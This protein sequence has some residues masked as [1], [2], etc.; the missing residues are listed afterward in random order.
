[1]AAMSEEE[2]I[3]AAIAAS[4][5]D[6]TELTT[7]EQL[8]TAFEER[9]HKGGGMIHQVNL[10][11]Q[12]SDA[13]KMLI[14]VHHAP[15]SICGYMSL[16]Y[17]VIL[18]RAFAQ[19][20]GGGGSSGD[21]H[22]PASR[23]EL[24]ELEPELRNVDGVRVEV[25]RAMS[26]VEESRRRYIEAHRD[27]FPE[28]ARK[29]YMRAWVANYE[30]SDYLR[31]EPEEVRREVCFLRFNQY[32]EY[33]SARHEER[34]RMVEEARFGGSKAGD[35]SDVAC[36]NEGDSMF[37]VESFGPTERT[38]ETPAEFL[39][40]TADPAGIS[41][42]VGGVGK[43]AQPR[44]VVLDLNGHFS[45]SLAMPATGH[46][47]G[48]D[49]GEPTLHVLNTTNTSY[50]SGMTGS[51]AM[52]QEAHEIF[53]LGG[54]AERE[55]GTGALAAE[56]HAPAGT[57]PAVDL[58]KLSMALENCDCVYPPSAERNHDTRSPFVAEGAERNYDTPLLYLGNRRVAEDAASLRLLGCT[59]V[60]NAAPSQV[61]SVLT[62]V[63][64]GGPA[65]LHVDL[66]DRVEAV[67]ATATRAAFDEAATFI[68]AA[69]SGGAAGSVVLVH[70][71]G[72]VSRSA[73]IVLFFLIA[74]K[75]MS[76]AGAWRMVREAREVIGPNTAFF[77]VLLD[78]EME[79]TG[80]ETMQRPLNDQQ[81]CFSCLDP[82]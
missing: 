82:A 15:E 47:S 1:M 70:C 29:S 51:R 46:H 27:Q 65:Y 11:N 31:A 26:F 54:A 12:F 32:P 24:A 35:K 38:L 21:G 39:T 36:Y 4:I 52:C 62:A 60:V 68:D 48:G 79:L 57:V 75:G 42:G 16:A 9:A 53:A 74:K 23:L 20:D 49:G 59:H 2:M 45:C 80:K 69:M 25:D 37:I 81:R 8:D 40:R 66:D 22:A 64:E 6:N 78:A 19:P 17:A 73:S 67:D 10:L 50:V 72:G 41:A 76:L 7:A 30:I 58:E 61:A 71:A 77:N 18:A 5:A 44:I 3:A 43:V 14:E 33:H 34:E 28:S 55:G 63:E 56:R 13:W